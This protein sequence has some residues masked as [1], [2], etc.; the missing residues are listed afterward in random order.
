VNLFCTK[1]R[2][3]PRSDRPWSRRIRV[4]S[5]G[6]VLVLLIPGFAASALSQ[7]PVTAPSASALPA[8]LDPSVTGPA[9]A[10]D[11]SAVEQNGQTGANG[12]FNPANNRQTAREQAQRNITPA[13]PSEFQRMVQSTTGRLLPVYGASLFTGTP[14]TFAPVTD[15]PVGPGYVLGPGDQIDLQLSGQINQRLHLLVDRT[16]A[17]SVPGLGAI[18][19]AGLP[20]G[21]L[22][23]FLNDRLGRIY[24]NFTLNANLGS[25]RTIQVFV[26]GQARSPGAYSISSLSSL[27]NA[28]FASGGALPQGSLRDIQVERGGTTIDH[29]DL[30][31][32]LLHGDKSHDIPLAT[33]DV[34]FIPFAGPQVAVSGSVEHP[35]IYEMKGDTTAAQALQFAGGETAVAASSTVRLQRVYEHRERS[36]SAI[37]PDQAATELLRN[38]DILSVQPVSDRF[39]NAVTLRGNVANPGRYVWHPGMHIADLIPDKESL[40]TRNY[41]RQR[42]RLGQ[43]PIEYLPDQDRVQSQGENQGQD[44]D[45]YQN[46]NQDQ[47]LNPNQ[48]PGQTEGALQV[49]G[50]QPG[51]RTQATTQSSS[52]SAT[53]GGSSVGAAL[54]A[55]N[56][57]FTAKNDVVLSAPDIDWSYAVIERLSPSDLTT[58][59]IPFNLG[60]LVLDHDSSQNFELL[61]GDVITIFSK[62]DIHVPSNQQTRFVRLEGEFNSSGIYSVQ[63]GETLRGLLRRAGGFTPEAYLYA[64]EFTRESTRRVEQ[65]RLREYADQLDAQISSVTAANQSRAVSPADQVAAAASETD[66]RS[67]VTRLRSVQPIGRIV[68]DLK[69]DSTGIDAVPDIALEDGDRF[70]VPHVPASVTVQ[71][72]VYNANAFLF[73]RDQRVIDYLRQAG[74]PD[75]DADKH[76]L[77]LLRADGSVVSSQYSNVLH[78]PIYPGD[79]IVVPPIL[80]K[81]AF[82]QRI[83]DIATIV[84]NLGVGIAAISIAATQ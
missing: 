2:D 12:E 18:H 16:G 22:T 64:S 24:R 84:G 35:A 73:K 37:N 57:P 56:G 44:Q 61:A 34:I 33:G 81:R 10:A 63:P 41:W 21:E 51:Q 74:G 8:A 50:N 80:D 40:I 11:D 48:M 39:R 20:Y 46:E 66:A 82:L 76:R 71:G 38:G 29:F 1:K 47:T 13:P 59:L 52:G 75:R 17:I 69:P 53:G 23:N 65:Q 9:T 68:L 30:Y 54:T 45:Q 60:K 6:V 58:S 43:V 36:F 7:T 26:V 19:V 5:A 70:V 62:S 4:A 77:F 49:Q 25:L 32:L 14:S 3:L 83:V 79:T 31:D 42:E 67:A 15:V 55:N 28:I 78:A 27:T 72:Q